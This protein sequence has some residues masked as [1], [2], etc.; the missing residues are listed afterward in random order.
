M[1]RIKTVV[2]TGLWGLIN[3]AGVLGRKLGPIEWLTLQDYRDVLAVNLLGTIDV[4]TV[5]LPL[6]KQERGR[7]VNTASVAGRFAM[8]GL[9]AYNISKYGVE[10]FN[11][12]L[13]QVVTYTSK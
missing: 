6:V 8:Q 4:T 7:I 13:R 3:N 5:F 11:D 9:A 1:S 10:A 12:T 2:Y